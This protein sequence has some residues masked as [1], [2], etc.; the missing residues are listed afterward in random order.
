MSSEADGP[1][2]S[3]TFRGGRRKTEPLV[4]GTFR[5]R[6][7]SPSFKIGEGAKAPW[8]VRFPSASASA[9]VGLLS[10]DPSKAQGRRMFQ[11]ELP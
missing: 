2:K 7:S 4:S 1:H 5:R 3:M 8:R 11:V 10:P 9:T 6:R